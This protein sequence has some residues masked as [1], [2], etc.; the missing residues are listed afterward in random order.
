MLIDFGSGEKFYTILFELRSPDYPRGMR[1]EIRR[2][3]KKIHVEQVI[4]YSKYANF[5]EGCIL[6]RHDGVKT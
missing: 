3:V 4:A 6:K 1:L 2:E 5:F